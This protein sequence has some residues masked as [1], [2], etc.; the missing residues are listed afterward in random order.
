[1]FACSSQ[2]QYIFLYETIMDG[3]THDFDEFPVTSLKQRLAQLEDVDQDGLSG[4]EKEFRV[5][6]SVLHGRLCGEGCVQEKLLVRSDL[7]RRGRP[8]AEGMEWIL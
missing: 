3:I 4:A 5:S 1:M 7:W 6:L 8:H 2:N